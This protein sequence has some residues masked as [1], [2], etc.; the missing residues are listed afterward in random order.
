M[1]P[2]ASRATPG[3]ASAWRGRPRLC[4]ASFSLTAA[5]AQLGW[6]VR[7]SCLPY[8]HFVALPTWLLCLLRWRMWLRR[9]AP[10]LRQLGFTLG[11]FYL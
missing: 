6:I 2:A 9:T 7:I 5:A 10:L 1:A 3:G 11:T 4:M 8:L